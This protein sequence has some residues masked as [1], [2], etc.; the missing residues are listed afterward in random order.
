MCIRELPDPDSREE[1]VARVTNRVFRSLVRRCQQTDP[2]Q[3]PNMEE[4]I[5]ELKQ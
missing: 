5:E 2:A 3:R 4:I 1:Q